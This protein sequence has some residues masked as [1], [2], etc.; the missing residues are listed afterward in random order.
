[1]RAR[2]TIAMGLCLVSA[3]CTDSAWKA[4]FTVPPPPLRAQLDLAIWYDLAKNAMIG[5]GNWIASLW[6]NAGD[7]KTTDHH[8]RNLACRPITKGQQCSFDLIRDGGPVNFHGERAPD[9]LFCTA[10]LYQT[11][12]GWAI[13]HTPPHGAGHSQTSMKC[14]EISPNSR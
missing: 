12:D 2:L 13:K 7:G 1:M 3:A 10:D 9:R 6:S 8:I 14:E 4:A 5:N 11:A